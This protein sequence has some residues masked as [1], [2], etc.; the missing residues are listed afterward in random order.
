M[1]A[2][3]TIGETAPWRAVLVLIAHR[4]QVSPL[5]R[6]VLL[7]CAS[8]ILFGLV[9]GLLKLS[10]AALDRGLLGLFAHW[11]FWVLLAIGGCAVLLNQR[12]YQETEMSVSTPVLNICQLLVSLAFGVFVLAEQLFASPLNAVLELIGL[13]IMVLGV[14]KLTTRAA[15]EPPP[16]ADSA[17]DTPD[18]ADSPAQSATR[19]S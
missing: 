18:D 19:S 12:A 14:I 16:V 6:G 1:R 10:T 7:G 15:D 8:G 5:I 9:A 4:A 2:E 13:A 17:A 3:R 11:P